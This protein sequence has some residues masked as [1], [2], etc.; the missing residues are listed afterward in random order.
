MSA[1]KDVQE[2]ETQHGKAQHAGKRFKSSEI[3][4]KLQGAI[5]ELKSNTALAEHNAAAIAT[6]EEVVA[7]LT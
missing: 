7:D 5:Q 3:V 2:E 1:K 6:L 4:E